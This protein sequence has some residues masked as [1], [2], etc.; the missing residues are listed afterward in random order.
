[1][2]KRFVTLLKRKKTSG[3][4][5]LPILFASGSANAKVAK[6]YKTFLKNLLVLVKSHDIIVV[7]EEYADTD[8]IHSKKYRSNFE[9]GATRAANVAYILIK[10]VLNHLLLKYWKRWR[11]LFGSSQGI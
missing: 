2:K 9:L 10:M 4:N 1:L 3:K 8:P 6:E 7:V 5:R 11:V